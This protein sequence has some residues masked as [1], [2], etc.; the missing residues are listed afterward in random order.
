[1][2]SHPHVLIS[3]YFWDIF[4]NVRYIPYESYL[5]T[6]VKDILLTGGTRNSS[7]ALT[8][9]HLRLGYLGLTARLTDSLTEGTLYGLVCISIYLIDEIRSR[10]LQ[11]SVQLSS[12]TRRCA[13][14]LSDPPSN[15]SYPSTENAVYRLVF[16]ARISGRYSVHDPSLCT[17][18]TDNKSE[19]RETTALGIT[20]LV[21]KMASSF[22][23][24]GLIPGLKSVAELTSVVVNL[25]QVSY[26]FKTAMNY[27]LTLWKRKVTRA[28][29]THEKFNFYSNA[30]AGQTFLQ[31]HRRCY[32]MT[33]A[34]LCVHSFASFHVIP[35]SAAHY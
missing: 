35:L 27:T 8:G 5:F 26:M 22:G 4:L 32:G 1:M 20:Q 3:A 23:D 21:L 7:G 14:W 29:N 6:L 31:R 9:C 19:N 12:Y 10:T 30:I 16:S 24:G 34:S 17:Y 13:G 25:F 2:L 18:M 28:R 11:S 33:S 15:S